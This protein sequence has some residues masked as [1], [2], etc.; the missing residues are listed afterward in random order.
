M[1][2]FFI[3]LFM[4][5]N[6]LLVNAQTVIRSDYSTP[7][8]GSSNEA[9]KVN[10]Y[11]TQYLVSLNHFLDFGD[12]NLSVRSSV[13]NPNSF[14]FEFGWIG[15][16]G[17]SYNGVDFSSQMFDLGANYTYVLSNSE[18]TKLLLTMGL[19]PSLDFV[20][21]SAYDKIEKKSKS[22][23]KTTI[24]GYIYPN[25]TFMYK[26]I[27]LSIGYYFR[28]PEFKFREKDG[29]DGFFAFGIGWDWGI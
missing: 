7:A 10:D 14:G 15:A 6:V 9:S 24:D 5:A 25:L 12:F 27:S 2:K 11:E 4:A 3:S 29:A 28:A 21:A 22:K 18:K 20:T 19:G 16:D 17:G 26:H 8:S 23:T 13:F 1:K